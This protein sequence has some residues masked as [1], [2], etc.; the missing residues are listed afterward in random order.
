MPSSIIALRCP[1]CKRLFYLTI[2]S[3]NPYFSRPL[4][5]TKDL[6]EEQV[7]QRL[8]ELWKEIKRK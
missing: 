1:S 3:E 2:E 7:R 5:A 4:E 8:E 6:T